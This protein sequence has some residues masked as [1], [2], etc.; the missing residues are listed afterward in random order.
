M[1]TRVSLLTPRVDCKLDIYI[2]GYLLNSLSKLFVTDSSKQGW[3]ESTLLNVKSNTFIR[4]VTDTSCCNFR[5]NS[6]GLSQA[7]CQTACSFRQLSNWTHGM[8]GCAKTSG[9][10]RDSSLTRL[11]ETKDLDEIYLRYNVPEND[12]YRIN[13]TLT[14]SST[15]NVSSLKTDK[16]RMSLTLSHST[17]DEQW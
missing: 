8:S 16:F 5:S 2:S 9:S 11:V 12:R 10:E 3:C 7:L 17:C 6:G 15:D 13:L 14:S 4:A 1:L